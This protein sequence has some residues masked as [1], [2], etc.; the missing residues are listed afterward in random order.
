MPAGGSYPF[1]K[2]FPFI[3]ALALVECRHFVGAPVRLEGV[4]LQDDVFHALVEDDVSGRYR[5][6]DVEFPFGLH[7]FEALI[8][9]CF[10]C[11]GR[12]EPGCHFR[13]GFGEARQGLDVVERGAVAFSY[14]CFDGQLVGFE[15]VDFVLNVHGFCV[16]R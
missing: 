13:I 7:L 1:R 9:S 6:S 14:D 8:C 5:F 11:P 3:G 2:L 4:G 16:Y 15:L 12:C 10:V